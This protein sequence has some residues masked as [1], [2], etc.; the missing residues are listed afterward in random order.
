MLAPDAFAKAIAG[1]G[2]CLFPNVLDSETT[3]ALRS[4][5]LKWVDIC[6]EF[7]IRN[8]INADGDGTAHHSIGGDD[9]IDAFIDSHLFHPYLDLFFGSAPYILHACNPVG[10]LPNRVNYVHNIH[11]DVRTYIPD[12]N[13]RMNVLVMLDDFTPENGATHVLTGSHRQ[14]EPPAPEAFDRDFQRLTGPA[15]SVVLF[16]SYLWHRGGLNITDRARVALTLS[17]GPAYIKPQLDYARMLGEDYGEGLSKQTRQVLGYTSRV[18]TSLDEWYR[19]AA[20][21]L[22]RSDQG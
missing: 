16:N 12:Y 7:Q 2:W 15:G 13:M 3:A 8:G 22:Y 20:T 4:D 1:D 14:A 17:Y 9:S 19:P 18:P 6:R 5:S 21:R 11:R 10:G